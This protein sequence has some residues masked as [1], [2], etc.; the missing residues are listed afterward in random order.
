RQGD[1][2]PVA[3]EQ[4]ESKLPFQIFDGCKDRRMRPSQLGRRCLK[5]ALA[6]HSVETLQL[7]DGHRLHCRIT[8]QSV[9][10]FYHF[11][12]ICLA[13]D[14]HRLRAYSDTKLAGRNNDHAL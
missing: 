1:A 13:Y 3:V 5:P 9:S 6:Y 4:P 14:R 2:I 8:L 7:V 10:R 11:Y 12:R